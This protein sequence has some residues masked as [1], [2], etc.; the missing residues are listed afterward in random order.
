MFRR[1]IE[2]F[3]Q[4][5]EGLCLCRGEKS[6]ASAACRADWSVG[7]VF[8]NLQT[9]LLED[10]NKAAVTKLVIQIITAAARFLYQ[11]SVHGNTVP[12]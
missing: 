12:S 2:V 5:A 7:F 3:V 4:A 1:F 6:A 9:L 10:L 11:L 8:Q